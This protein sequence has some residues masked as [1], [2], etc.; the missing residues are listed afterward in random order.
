MRVRALRQH[1]LIKTCYGLFYK[2]G[3][4]EHCSPS[5]GSAAMVRG[6]QSLV[7]YKGRLI[8]VFRPVAF[9][10]CLGNSANTLTFARSNSGTT[11]TDT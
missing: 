1:P 9:W 8:L 2:R 7:T 10:S 3:C 5:A 4:Q 6:I 11:G